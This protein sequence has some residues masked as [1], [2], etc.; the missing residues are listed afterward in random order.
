[1]SSGVELHDEFI[2]PLCQLLSHKLI[3]ST[4]S[5]AL[6]YTWEVIFILINIF[7]INPLH[8]TNNWL[9]IK[10]NGLIEILLFFGVEFVVYNSS[11][12]HSI[13]IAFPPKSQTCIIPDAHVLCHWMSVIVVWNLWFE[14]SQHLVF[15]IFFLNFRHWGL[16]LIVSWDVSGASPGCILGGLGSSFVSRFGLRCSP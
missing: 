11:P 9:L 8:I 12:S 3:K 16:V 1:M 10:Q 7:P 4:S 2:I 14:F 6:M 5:E 15:S 13:R